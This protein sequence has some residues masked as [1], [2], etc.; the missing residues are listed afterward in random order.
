[1]TDFLPKDYSVPTMSN[2]M[3]F[4]AGDNT[5]RIL[6]SALTGYE[7]FNIDNKPV[8]AKE[9]WDTVPTD[10]KTNGAIKHFWAFAVYNYEDKR[11]QILEITQKTIQTA[12]QS[13]TENKKW[14]NPSA[15]DITVNRSGTTMA[16][17]E[18]TVM[19]NP[20]S[21]LLEGVKEKFETM[22]INLLALFNGADPFGGSASNSA[23]K[24]V[25]YPKDDIKPEDIPF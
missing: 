4:K 13:L 12:I 10:L 22:N 24:K 16:D 5:F 20:K 15:Y 8:R 21:D 2:Y 14:G 19:P 1:M 11:I 17:T 18:Y 6:S 25:E 3:K 7:Y 23:S 9:M